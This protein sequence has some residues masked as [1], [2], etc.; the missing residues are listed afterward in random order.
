MHAQ[1]TRHAHTHVHCFA[2][3]RLSEVVCAQAVSRARAEFKFSQEIFSRKIA[4]STHTH[5]QHGRTAGR[6][7]KTMSTTV[8]VH[9][10]IYV[11]LAAGTYYCVRECARP[12]QSYLSYIRADERVCLCQCRCWQIFTTHVHWLVLWGR[13]D[14]TRARIQLTMMRVIR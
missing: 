11:T 7:T 12:P 13:I 14:G 4:I 5:A 9:Q 10:R 3:A 1:H 8:G 2:R 6:T